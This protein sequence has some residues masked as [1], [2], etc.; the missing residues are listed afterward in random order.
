MTTETSLKKKLN[1]VFLLTYTLI[2]DKGKK[3]KYKENRANDIIRKYFTKRQKQEC[4]R[5]IR[6]LM[7]F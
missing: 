2:R 6:E 7:L 5:F 4:S 1:C 3:I